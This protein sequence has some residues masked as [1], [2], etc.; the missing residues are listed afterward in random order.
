MG[1]FDPIW[2][3]ESHK[4]PYTEYYVPEHV[5]VGKVKLLLSEVIDYK[6]QRACV[7][8]FLAMMFFVVMCCGCAMVCACHGFILLL[9]DPFD[10]LGDLSLVQSQSY[11]SS[12]ELWVWYHGA[13]S[14]RRSVVRWTY[15]LRRQLRLVHRRTSLALSNHSIYIFSNGWCYFRRILVMVNLRLVSRSVI[16]SN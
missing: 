2:A 6:F 15:Q 8:E 9:T 1:K 4:I 7:A 3:P 16:M 11:A 14:V 12:S 5:T 13:C 10:G